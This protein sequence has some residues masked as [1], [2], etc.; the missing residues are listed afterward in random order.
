MKKI[1]LLLF[2]A[3]TV[4]VSFAQMKNSRLAS[5]NVKSSKSNLINK[6][7]LNLQKMSIQDIVKKSNADVV[8]TSFDNIKDA[9]QTRQKA[10]QAAP[11]VLYGPPDGTLFFGFSRDFRC[12]TNAL[13]L[14]APAQVTLD[15]IPYSDTQSAVFSWVIPTPSGNVSLSSITDDQGVLNWFN[16]IAP[17]GSGYYM[18]K[19]TATAAGSSSSFQLGQGLA[20]QILT[21]GDVAREDPWYDGTRLGD[22][23]EYPP[24]T[25]A[26]IQ[27][28]SD[29][30]NCYG[31]FQNGNAFSSKYANP[32]YGACT[33]F[34]QVMPK[35]ASPL[36]AESVSVLAY[37]NTTAV[38]P[39]GV[40]KIQ[41]YYLNDDSSLGDLIAESTT[42]K[43]EIT[44]SEYGEGAF[45]FTFEDV[46]DGLTVDKPLI[47]GT[48][49][50]VAVILSGFDSTWDFNLLFGT[51]NVVGSSYTLHG[52]NVATFGYSNAP[53]IPR[54]DLYIE[55][56]GMFNCLSVD[57]S[58]SS[59]EF[60]EDGGWGVTL[61]Q[62]GQTY[63]EVDIYSSF[64]M[65][66]D[67][68]WIDSAPDWVTGYDYDDSYFLSDNILAFFFSADPLP[69]DVGGRS[70]EIVLASYGVTATIPVTQGTVTGIP[71]TKVQLTAV[72]LNG[73][74][75]VLKYPA[76][77][78]SV[79]VYNV[80]GQK[81]A[82]Y[83]LPATGSFTIPAGNYSKGVY[84]FNFTGANG[85]TTVKM[86]K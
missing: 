73:D 2:F 18:P 79:S 56:N 50:P 34:M 17:S 48:Q 19:V 74:S 59:I 13:F 26:N 57:E 65:S 22:K 23:S 21:A 40:L 86:M 61:V 25:I 42:D 45:I 6:K 77:A 75:F 69:A 71:S 52:N 38:P 32:T 80:A 76:S 55:F 83:K 46:E 63:N 47:L 43:F 81:L 9:V 33:G 39:G 8:T 72:S 54:C 4:S 78:A 37:T 10:I 68:V 16:N 44:Q 12:Y 51:N 29:G 15:F 66:N 20:A 24:L 70:G 28:Q 27:E 64:G 3:L 85:S 11:V 35:L 82:A 60:P 67:D 41:F 5:M 53:D 36:Y 31:G 62:D 49:A 7:D 1:Y 30:G 58:T 14:Y 84:L